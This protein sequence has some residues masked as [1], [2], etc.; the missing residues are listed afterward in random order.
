MRTR[1]AALLL[2]L[3]AI[4]ACGSG[5]SKGEV[6]GKNFDPA[7]TWIYLQPQYTETCS[8]KPLICTQHLSGYIPIPVYDPDHWSLKLR[9][10]SGD[11]GCKTGW[12]DVDSQTYHD[13]A[14]GA[15]Y[16]KSGS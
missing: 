7:H 3:C 2:A 1:L 5:V 8:G 11:N 16:S 6:I 4:A 10:C 12:V 14:I 9:D 15:F 13:K